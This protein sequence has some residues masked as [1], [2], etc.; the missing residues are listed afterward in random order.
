MIGG[1]VPAVSQTYCP[2]E[3]CPGLLQVQILTHGL[4][5]RGLRLRISNKLPAD[6]SSGPH[7]GGG[8]G[9]DRNHGDQGAQASRLCEKEGLTVKSVHRTNP[10]PAGSGEA[11]TGLSEDSEPGKVEEEGAVIVSGSARRATREVGGG[12]E[13][14][15]LNV[16]VPNKSTPYALIPS[17]SAF[18]EGPVRMQLRSE[19]VTRASLI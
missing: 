10:C 4:W 17:V 12:R 2:G 19:G 13:M 5:S 15:G 8:D 18:R 3:S 9:L 14:I 6:P 7:D 1:G 11:P 16:W